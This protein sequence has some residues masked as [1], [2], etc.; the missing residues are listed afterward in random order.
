MDTVF[1]ALRVV[2]A[3]GAVFGALLFAHRWITK[4]RPGSK[5]R[6]RQIEVVARQGLGAKA[7]IAVVDAG[8]RR[9][10]LG[11][12]EHAV[13][14]LDT[15]G[16]AEAPTGEPELVTAQPISV[17]RFEQELRT[18]TIATAD[19]PIVVHGV[20]DPTDPH[21]PMTQTVAIMPA[22]GRV[23]GPATE[24]IRLPGLVSYTAANPVVP[25]ARPEVD[26]AVYTSRRALRQAE[27]QAAA[28]VRSAVQRPAAQGPLAGSVLSPTTW[29]QT[30]DALK[31]LR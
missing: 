31:K 2:V 28:E 17:A 24:A 4:G 3:L 15:L 7:G 9:Y 6:N 22:A 19:V 14:V 16:P 13:T 27:Q 29:R 1:L 20:A 8:G 30:F 23:P 18:V 21:G 26:P 12:T 10:L 5:P 25:A 11:V